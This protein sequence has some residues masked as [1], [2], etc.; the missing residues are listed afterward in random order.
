[1]LTIKSQLLYIINLHDWGLAETFDQN[2]STVSDHLDATQVLNSAA[3]SP[4]L[5]RSTLATVRTVLESET[6]DRIEVDCIRN[7]FHTCSGGKWTTAPFTRDSL[8]FHDGLSP[9]A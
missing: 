5:S 7:L 4:A 6:V 3:E 2:P 8:L 1:M 9:G